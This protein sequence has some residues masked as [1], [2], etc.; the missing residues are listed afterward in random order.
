MSQ[1]NERGGGRGKVSRGWRKASDLSSL[2]PRFS[3]QT[4]EERTRASPGCGRELESLQRIWDFQT[5]PTAPSDTEIA[6]GRGGFPTATSPF[7]LGS[8]YEVEGFFSSEIRSGMKVQ[9]AR[10][11]EQITC[12]SGHRGCSLT[13]TRVSPLTHQSLRWNQFGEPFKSA[14]GV[15]TFFSPKLVGHTLNHLSL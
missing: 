3:F 11:D 15:F 1:G 13:Q 5:F 12:F 6:L 4:P 14:T 9:K 7:K 10:L 8:P 2:P